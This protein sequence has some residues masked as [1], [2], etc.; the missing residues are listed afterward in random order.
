[1]FNYHTAALLSHASKVMLKILQARFQQYVNQELPD[2]Q[3]GFRKWQR[4]QNQITN[5]LW[6]IEKAKELYKNIYLC[7]IDCAKALTVWIRTNWEILKEMGVTNEPYLP[8]EKS[9]CRSKINS[10]NQTWNNRLVANWERSI[11]RLYI[12]ILL[13]YLHV[14]YIMW[15]SGLDEVQAGIK[16]AGR[17]ISNLKYADDTSLM[18]ESEE[19][20]S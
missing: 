16:I 20:K 15:N 13:I 19:L 5:I 12:V 7:F 3:G 8:L 18:A 2:V 11:S 17:N 9:G 1:M 6:I 10:Q 4:N 14:E